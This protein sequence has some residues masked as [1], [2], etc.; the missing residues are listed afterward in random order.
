MRKGETR[1][2]SSLENHDQARNSVSRINPKTTGRIRGTNR[3]PNSLLLRLL[4]WTSHFEISIFGSRAPRGIRNRPDENST[5]T[6]PPK[7]RK[8]EKNR[9]T[10]ETVTGIRLAATDGVLEEVDLADETTGMI[11]TIETIE[12]T[13]MMVE[14]IGIVETT[15]M[16]VETIGTID[17]ASDPL[18]VR[19]KRKNDVPSR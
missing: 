10:A 13:T 15:T 3:V 18:P 11:E 14:T 19:M 16:M 12:T 6:N 9:T 5:R 17:V 1:K 7:S 8:K 2:G 4:R